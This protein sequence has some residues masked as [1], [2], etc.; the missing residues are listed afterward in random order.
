M[1]LIWLGFLKGSTD[2]IAAVSAQAAVV[3]APKPGC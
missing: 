3:A 2:W 1:L